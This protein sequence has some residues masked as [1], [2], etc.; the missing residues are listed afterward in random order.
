MKLLFAAAAL[1][2][3]TVA[4]AA[5]DYS[6][7][8]KALFMSNQLANVKPPTTLR[9]R[10]VKSGSLEA[11]FEDRVTVALNVRADRSCCAANAEFLSGPRRLALPAVETA[12]GNPAV[13]Y[14]L[15]REIREMSRLTKGQS[16]YFRKRI[17]MAVYQGAQ[18]RD[19]Q[20]PFRG[21]TVAAR[22]ITIT[23]YV[24]D[25]MHARFEKFVGKEY[26][27]TLSDAVPGGVYAIGSRI[28]GDGGAV[29]LA[30]EMLLDGATSP[31]RS[32]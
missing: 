7:A 8:E 9:Y 4:G 5:E 30:E 27:F 19:V 24:D 20:L 10:Y 21:K 2:L 1:L 28:A 31:P 13:L 16:N 23:P 18:I 32:P 15:E 3:A 11:G 29:L 17:R 14:F 22:Q 6:A 25:P 12:E 26:V